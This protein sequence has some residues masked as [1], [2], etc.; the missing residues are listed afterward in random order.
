[1]ADTKINTNNY[2]YQSRLIINMSKRSVED[3][4]SEERTKLAN[5]RT[6]LSYIRTSLAA[7]A[8]GFIILRF[9][10]KTKTDY[11]I[12]LAIILIG[13]FFLIIGIIQYNKEKSFIKRIR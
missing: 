11:Y 4:L 3:K 5:E 12:G 13:I 8:L 1:M 2:K 9:L 6:L 7:L 10:N